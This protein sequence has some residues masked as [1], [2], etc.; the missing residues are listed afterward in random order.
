LYTNKALGVNRLAGK[1][2]INLDYR[3][4]LIDQMPVDFSA[5]CLKIPQNKKTA[6]LKER[7]LQNS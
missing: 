6:F 2:S 1:N 5:T 7:C 4:E 3:A